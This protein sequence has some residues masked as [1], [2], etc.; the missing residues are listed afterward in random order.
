MRRLSIQQANTKAKS[1]GRMSMILLI[2][3]GIFAFRVIARM[4]RTRN[5]LR[6]HAVAD[7]APTTA[8]VT[9][10]VPVLNEE[11]RLLPCLEGLVQQ[12]DSVEQIIVID[13][14]SSDGTQELVDT[15]MER[16]DRVRLI[17]APA[18]PPGLNGKAWQL[19]HGAAQIGEQIEWVLT[20]D[21]DVRPSPH[22]VNAL[23]AHAAECDVRALSVATQQRLQGAA[24]GL[25]HPSM[26]TTLVYRFGIPGHA[27]NRVGQVQANGQ[28]FLIRRELLHAVGGFGA[29]TESLNEDVTLARL[30]A[31]HGEPA[32]FYEAGDL[33][34]V[35]MYDSAQE[36]WRNWPRSL[37]LRD[38]LTPW[39]SVI[40][41][42]EV[43][44]VQALPLLAAP[45]SGLR[46]GWNDPLT[47]L[48][49]GLIA[50]RC[51]V[52]AGTARAYESR[53]W[54]YWL[55]PLCDF[56]VSGRLWQSAFTRTQHWRGRVVTRGERL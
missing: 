33:V 7:R 3:Q 41:L 20:I 19:A 43:S 27:T 6:I 51:G 23:L 36:T 4:L 49:L 47:T 21:A 1:G 55:S 29:V 34:S 40:G 8:S 44:L 42:A 17:S 26:L 54:T 38:A 48:N 5:G 52:L 31:R 14:G 24:E 53:P 16:D 15:Y 12:G 56:A 39:S 45:I 37:P 18:A 10:L 30:I 46:R 35:M 11:K 50:T 28:C 9:V 2:V 25:I 32:G 22:L 13:G